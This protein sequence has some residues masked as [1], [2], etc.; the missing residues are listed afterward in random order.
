[1]FTEDASTIES[2]QPI[3]F[4]RD[5]KICSCLNGHP[6]MSRETKKIEE[7][8]HDESYLEEL[9]RKGDLDTFVN[10][11][12]SLI[13]F[14]VAVSIAVGLLCYFSRKKPVKRYM[15][16]NNQVYIDL[17]EKTRIRFNLQVKATEDV[18]KNGFTPKPKPPEKTQEEKD[19]EAAAAKENSMNGEV[20]TIEFGSSS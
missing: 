16:F 6:T 5:L 15:G 14:F 7:I 8:P 19:K 13:L 2:I 12:T 17:A 10:F 3:F 20:I 9:A 1:M 18:L 11:I 4:S